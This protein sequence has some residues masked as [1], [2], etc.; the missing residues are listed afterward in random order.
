MGL[1]DILESACNILYFFS[2]LKKKKGKW[3]RGE[4]GGGKEKEK[5]EVKS[6]P[7]RLFERWV[8]TGGWR[9]GQILWYCLVRKTASPG[10]RCGEV[11]A[12]DGVLRSFVLRKGR[13]KREEVGEGTE[14]AGGQLQGRGSAW[15]GGVEGQRFRRRWG[16]VSLCEEGR[17]QGEAPAAL[18]AQCGR[19]HPV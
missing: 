4:G 11:R 9:T 19:P 14:G 7:F 17:S 16:G 12:G 10:A 6:V 18:G 2:S 5:C 8:E 15:W 3:G 1:R 13:G